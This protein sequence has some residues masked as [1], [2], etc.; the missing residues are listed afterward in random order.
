M[1]SREMV[2]VLENSCDGGKGDG[3]LW[4]GCTGRGCGRRGSNGVDVG[5]EGVMVF[6]LY[7]GEGRC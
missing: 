5:A 6:E 3:G 7:V 4:F 2:G 1:V